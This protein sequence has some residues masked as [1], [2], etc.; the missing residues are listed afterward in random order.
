MIIQ[1]K[2]APELGRLRVVSDGGNFSGCNNCALVLDDKCVR[3]QQ[4]LALD[5]FNREIYFE[6]VNP[7]DN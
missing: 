1:F 3:L 6:K 2:E 5:C 4:T 7:N